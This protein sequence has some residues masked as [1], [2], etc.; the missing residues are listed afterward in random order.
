MSEEEKQKLLNVDK[1][2]KKEKMKSIFWHVSTP[3]AQSYESME[4]MKREALASSV[5]SWYCSG[6]DGGPFSPDIPE[7]HVADEKK[8]EELYETRMKSAFLNSRGCRYSSQFCPYK[9]LE[10]D[11]Q[12]LERKLVDEVGSEVI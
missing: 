12:N 11:E 5:G 3:V 8:N 2:F 1:E 10:V 4:F 6:P 7:T 9:S